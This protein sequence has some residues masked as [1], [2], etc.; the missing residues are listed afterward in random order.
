MCKTLHYTLYPSVQHR[1]VGSSAPQASCWLLGSRHE[2]PGSG[3]EPG[4]GTH[5]LLRDSTSGFPT[6]CVPMGWH[7]RRA[8]TPPDAGR[9]SREEPRGGWGPGS[10][11]GITTPWMQAAVP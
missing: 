5:V 9:K 6:S 10:V 8:P 7:E 1:E 4:G 11:V 2:N 3:P